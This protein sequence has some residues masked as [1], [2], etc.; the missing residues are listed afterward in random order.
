MDN[1]ALYS[2][3]CDTHARLAF[4]QNASSLAVAQMANLGKSFPDAVA[5]A[6][7][8]LGAIHAPIEACCRLWN[9][10]DE[11]CR[12]TI[13]EMATAGKLVP[14]WGSSFVKDLPDQEL[15]AAHEALPEKTQ[16]R[17]IR[18]TGVVNKSLSRAQEKNVVLFPNLGL[19]T[20]IYAELLGM[21]PIT[22][23][24]L[25][26]S[27]RLGPWLNIYEANYRPGVGG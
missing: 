27:G 9:M 23:S 5:A 22:A 6:C 2:I 15:Q 12:I 10:P 20:A 11:D 14:G 3:I 26:L 8:T 7:L 21:S 13:N 19:Y 16:Q 4:R 25:A 18:L 1:S 24:S 17:L